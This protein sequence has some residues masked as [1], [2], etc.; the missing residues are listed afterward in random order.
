MEENKIYFIVFCI[1]LIVALLIIIPVFSYEHKGVPYQYQSELD[2]C[3]SAIENYED[4]T[5]D[6][7][8]YERTNTD[9]NAFDNSYELERC[10]KII[11]HPDHYIKGQYISF[12]FLTVFLSLALIAILELIALGITNGILN[13]SS[14]S[15]W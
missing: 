14:S 7:I 8:N 6:L 5:V 11:D 2:Q 9:D 10:R 13:S 4:K 1:A 12:W 3:E 15:R